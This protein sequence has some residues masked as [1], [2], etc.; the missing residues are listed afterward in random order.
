MSSTQP[1]LDA[2]EQP[3]L[4]CSLSSDSEVQAIAAT[5]VDDDDDDLSS[6]SD[7][8]DIASFSEFTIVSKSQRA[9]PY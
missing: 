1:T 5:A 8:D 4:S 6:V 3:I 2:T 9:P 7:D